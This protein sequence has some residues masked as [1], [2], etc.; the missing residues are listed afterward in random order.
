MIPTTSY[1]GSLTKGTT[2]WGPAAIGAIGN[3]ASSAVQA[4]GPTPRKG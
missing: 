3:M 4:F 1:I 2:P